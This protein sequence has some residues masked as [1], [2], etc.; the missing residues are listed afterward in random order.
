MFKEP[1]KSIKKIQTKLVILLIIIM[2]LSINYLSATAK[3]TTNESDNEENPWTPEDEGAHFPCGCEWWMFYVTLELE[4]GEHWDASATFQYSTKKTENETELDECILLHYYFNRENGKCYDFS[5]YTIREKP[6]TFKK[7]VVDVKY[8]NNTMYGLYPKYTIHLEDDDKRFILDIEL[9]ASSSLPHWAIDEVT[10]G[11][12]PFGTGVARY[13]FILNLDANGIFTIDGKKHS[14]T[15]TG[16]FE[17]VWGNF[18]YELDLKSLKAK[19]FLKTLPKMWLLAKWIISEHS[20]KFPRSLVF[21]TDNYFGYDWAWAAFDNG[22]NLHLG[23]FHILDFVAEGPVLGVLSL[24][25]DRKTYYDFGDIRIRYGKKFLIPEAD[26]YLPLDIEIT[27]TKGDKTLFLRFN[28]T[29]EPHTRSVS[30][31]PPFGMSRSSAGIQTAGV[32]EGYYKDKEQEVPLNGVCTIGPWHQFSTRK[33]N[34]VKTEFL[35]PPKGLGY[36]FQYISHFR[37]FEFFIK[38]QLLPY[39]DFHF[40]IKRSPDLPPREPPQEYHFNDSKICLYVGGLGSNNYTTIQDAVDNAHTGDTVFVYNGTYVENV[41]VNKTIR[42][43]GED[44]D[45]VYIMAGDKD[46][47]KVTADGVEITGFTI[48]SEPADSYD[49]SAIDLSSSGNYVHDNNITKSEWYGIFIF[50]SSY[51]IIENNNIIDN[52]IDIWLCRASGNIIRYNNICDSK[53]NGIWLFPL[54]YGNHIYCNNI[55]GSRINVVN[56]DRA[57]TNIWYRN[58]WDDYVGLKFRRLADLNRDGIGNIP[59]KIS[60]LNWDRHPAMEPYEYT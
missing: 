14:A 20:I 24:T 60:R 8:Y 51:N 49:D 41:V 58:Y 13:G 40:Y 36:S 23:I 11:Y 18:S 25:T 6:L 26:A 44:K 17:H 21:T 55:M 28:S 10:G 35:L 22:W 39:P 50:N 27:A 9:D 30:I 12:F 5:T 3:I 52:D 54:S 29:T 56:Q 1:T 2:I 7:N 48:D 47:I 16:Y 43:I 15:G 42:L 34:A 32:V 59:Y 38:R 37:G 57:L 33:H 46:G 31:Y 19:E 53:Y 4:N 45:K